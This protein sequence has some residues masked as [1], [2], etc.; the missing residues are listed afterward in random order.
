MKFLVFL[1]LILSSSLLC[2][3]SKAERYALDSIGT[4]KVNGKVFILHKVD[5]G[6][7]MFAV[8]R[9]YNSTIKAIKEAN[10]G[11]QDN[12]IFG[13][14]IRV[15]Y[16]PPSKLSTLL[17][18]TEKKVEPSAPVEAAP[19]PVVERPA[20]GPGMHRVEAGQT[21]YSIAVKYG[22]LMADVRAWNKM[23]SDNI[24]IGQDLIISESVL[25]PASTSKPVAEEKKAPAID[26]KAPTERAEA[27]KVE[28]PIAKEPIPKKEA[29]GKKMSEQGIAE[30]IETELNSSKFL[31]LHR[32][33]PIGTLILVKNEFNQETVWVKVIGRI[34]ETS[35]NKD[36]VIKLSSRA[37]QKISPK[38]N[39][40]RASVSYVVAN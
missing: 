40:F 31:A 30:A 10:P 27:V 9:R 34:P 12:L 19:A 33:A 6:E 37:F 8:T 11:I 1:A 18:R 28:R 24:V 14:V 2:F 16:S 20:P 38:S 5:R 17:S 29:S 21:L 3:S 22:V 15:P 7:T 23:E 4:E 39:R 13:Q 32:T 25:N 36:V 26:T 35:V